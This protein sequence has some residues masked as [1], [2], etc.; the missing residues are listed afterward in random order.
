MRPIVASFLF[1]ICISSCLAQNAAPA[2]SADLTTQQIYANSLPSIVTLKADKGS[3]GVAFGTGFFALKDGIAVTAYHVIKNAKS[4]TAKFST[5]EVYDVSGVVDMD[6]VRDVALVRV[7]VAGRPLLPT[8]AKDPGVGGKA[9]V[10][11][12]PEGLEFSTS[13]GVIS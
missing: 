10:V 4:V 9:C 3:D 7:K 12:A 5:G 13:D 8:D 11:G 6:P 2:A 1:S